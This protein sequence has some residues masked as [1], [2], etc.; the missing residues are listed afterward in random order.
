MSARDDGVFVGFHISS[1]EQN[2]LFH[3][4]K[5]TIV[6][7]F[8]CGAFIRGVRA[9]VRACARVC[10]R[11]CYLCCRMSA[12]AGHAGGMPRTDRPGPLG[13]RIGPLGARYAGHDS[14]HQRTLNR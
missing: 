4:R 9:Y 11:A 7:K 14:R 12:D 8:A 1:V 2:R 13:G 6:F 10:V 3:G 5:W